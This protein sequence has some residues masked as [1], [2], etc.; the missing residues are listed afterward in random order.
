EMHHN[1]QQN[2][3]VDS[4]TE[5]TSDSNLIPYEQY[6]KDNAE[7]VV[8]SVVSSVPNDA[9]LMIMNKMYE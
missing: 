2:C 1:V 7:A 8:Q 6:V 3:V 5:H 9:V 4:N